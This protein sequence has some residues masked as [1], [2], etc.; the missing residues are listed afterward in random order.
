MN[1]GIC[2]KK[3]GL[4]KKALELSLREARLEKPPFIYT[5]NRKTV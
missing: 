5:M 1:V 2:L 3:E 4:V